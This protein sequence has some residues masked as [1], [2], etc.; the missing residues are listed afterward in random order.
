MVC[1]KCGYKDTI[2]KEKFSI[3]LCRLCYHFS[4]EKEQDFNNYIEEKIDWKLI[5]TYRKYGQTAG[6]PQKKGMA[7]EAEKGMLV[8]RPAWGYSVQE[9]NLIPNEDAP[10]VRSLFTTFLERDYSLNSMSKNFGLSL[11]GMKKVLA[12][13]TYLGEIKFA[14]KLHKGHHQSIINPETFYAVQRKLKEKLRPR[15]K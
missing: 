11:N 8:V 13:R 2:E 12:N 6:E 10:R 3:K 15:K 1:E 4:P 14:G 5:D 7:I 9:G